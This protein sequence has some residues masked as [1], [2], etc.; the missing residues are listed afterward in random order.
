MIKIGFLLY[1]NGQYGGVEK[2]VANIM[3]WLAN[4]RNF[5]IYSYLSDRMYEWFLKQG[6]SFSE[7]IHFD[8]Y[9]D[10]KKDLVLDSNNVNNRN[11]HLY[12]LKNTKLWAKLRYLKSIIKKSK[13]IRKW[14]K[15]NN[16]NVVHSLHAGGEL[17]LQFFLTKKVKTIYSIVDSSANNGAPLQWIGN[18]SYRSVFKFTD[19]L[20]FLSKGVYEEY[21]KIGAKINCEKIK[22][23]PCSFIDYTKT[24]IKEKDPL[25]IT[26]AAS[27]FE[28]AKNPIL[29]VRAA[30]I[31]INKY[32]K[33]NS[34]FLL[35]GGKHEE[36]KVRELINSCNLSK[37]ISVKYV[38]N[39]VDYLKTSLIFL[40]IQQVN[41]YPSQSLLEAMAC[42]NAIVATDVG[43][44]R[45]LVNEEVGFLVK[46]DAEE[47]AEAIKY[48]LENPEKA[49]GMGHKAREK[50]LNEHTIEKY[51]NYLINLYNNVLK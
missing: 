45:K 48:L 17:T 8:F 50:V 27:R 4:N 3:K 34:K 40:S 24:E 36:I 41:N 19:T 44:T 29:A 18:L 2:R 5:E 46:P 39:V 25:F 14:V 20:E 23:S 28:K 35:M 37:N 6:F 51:A 31:L 10:N 13:D 16:I 15:N 32:N 9:K 26:F 21:S 12:I 38:H 30:N 43:E 22:I 1:N 7:N 47:I 42:G 11:K 33:T 49:K